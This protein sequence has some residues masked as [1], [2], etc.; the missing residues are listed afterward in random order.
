[1]DGVYIEASQVCAYMRK[2][3]IFVAACQGNFV[4]VLTDVN[5]KKAFCSIQAVEPAQLSV[6]AW[7][8]FH[9]SI[10]ACSNEAN[11]LVQ[12]HLTLSDA[13]CWPRL[14]TMLDDVG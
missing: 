10:K 3:L 7:R 2:C 6:L 11:M 14:N 4:I 8:N 5:L 1:M 12:H 9:P 13:T